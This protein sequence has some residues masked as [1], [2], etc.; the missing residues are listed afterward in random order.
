[1]DK[2]KTAVTGNAILWVVTIAACA[3]LGKGSE[4]ALMLILIPVIAGA[5][6]IYLVAQAARAP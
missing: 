3:V 4:Q 6:S 1:M 5:V 2:M